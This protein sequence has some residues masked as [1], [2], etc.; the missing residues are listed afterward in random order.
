[1]SEPKIGTHVKAIWTIV[2]AGGTENKKILEKEVEI[3]AQ[4]IEGVEEP[5]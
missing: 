5:N 3:T 4:A 2:D 1:L